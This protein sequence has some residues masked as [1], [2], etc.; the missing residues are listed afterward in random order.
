MS[1]KKLKYI[2]PETV[3]IDSLVA[4]PLSANE[5][6]GATFERL[7]KELEKYGLIDLPIVLRDTKSKVLRIIAGHHRVRGW[8]EIGNT[9][10]IVIILEGELDKEEEFNLVNNLNAIRGDTTTSRVKRVIRSQELDV[11]RLDLFKHPLSKLLPKTADANPANDDMLRK[12][13]LR[14]MAIKVAGEL[15]EI[16]VDNRD[17]ELVCF[18]IE[19]KLVAVVHVTSTPPKVRGSVPI[20]KGV[21]EK[22]FR[23]WEQGLYD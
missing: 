9:T 15:A 13:K 17:E 14:D 10:I 19:G 8:K 1:K 3:A 2:G 11:T 20:F 21:L 12:A 7:K 23:E 6:D 18:A 16:I 5:E 4:N 22:A